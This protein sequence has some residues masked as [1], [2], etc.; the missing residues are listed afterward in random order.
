M[1][2][3]CAWDVNDVLSDILA[4]VKICHSEWIHFPISCS[5]KDIVHLLI[6]LTCLSDMRKVLGKTAMAQ[7]GASAPD[8]DTEELEQ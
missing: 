8:K 2:L 5:Y 3:C 4:T 6:L 1:K 7:V